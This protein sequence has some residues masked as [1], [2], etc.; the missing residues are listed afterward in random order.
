VIERTQEQ[1]DALIAQAR[2]DLEL[3]D[4]V[5]AYE[6][7]SM[8][9]ETWP[10]TALGIAGIAGGDAFTPGYVLIMVAQDGTMARYHTSL[11]YAVLAEW[12]E[13]TESHPVFGATREQRRAVHVALN[14]LKDRDSSQGY[15]PV[16]VKE[17]MWPDSSMGLGGGGSASL[18]PGSIITLVGADG[19]S[20]AIYH[21]DR[22]AR[23]VLFANGEGRCAQPLRPRGEEL[24]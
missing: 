15:R 8:T 7:E 9:E 23:R 13:M 24:S 10:T 16:A 2:Q 21:A 1:R 17:A 11:K 4:P 12:D 6:V 20:R 5:N 3:W 22:S 19:I 14:D 18:C